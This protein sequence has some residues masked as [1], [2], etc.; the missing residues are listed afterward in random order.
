MADPVTAGIGIATG[1]GQTVAGI[2]KNQ[3]ANKIDLPA[4]DPQQLALADQI[5]AQ[6]RSLQTGAAFT[7]LRDSLSR[8]IASSNAG[9]VRVSGGQ[10]GAA[11]LGLTRNAEAAGIGFNDVVAQGFQQ[12]QFFT[13]LGSSIV[14]EIAS[15]RL[16]VASLNKSQA[17]AEASTLISQGTGNLLGG[18]TDAV[19][20]GS[21]SGRD[22]GGLGEQVLN[23]IIGA[24][25]AG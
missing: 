1:L 3:K 23:A 21:G 20:S 9:I 24:L 6:S 16:E 19:S 17:K 12:Q 11:A 8:D 4:T 25:G 10:S 15:R 13:S 18:I 22:D 2:V 5:L 7:N 14:S